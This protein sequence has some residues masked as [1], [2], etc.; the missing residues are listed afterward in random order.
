MN[1]VIKKL[2]EEAGFCFWSDE[3][4]K[5]HGAIIDWSADYDKEFQKYTELLIKECI[6]ELKSVDGYYFGEFLA[7]K[8]GIE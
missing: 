3:E 1:P 6:K 8:F 7:Q 2:A 4:W 5:P